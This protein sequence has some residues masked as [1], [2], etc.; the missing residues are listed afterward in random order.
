M[1]HQQFLLMTLAEAPRLVVGRAVLRV[2]AEVPRR[3][4]ARMLRR[5]IPTTLRGTLVILMSHRHHLRRHLHP[6]RHPGHAL[7]R[8]RMVHPRLK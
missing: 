2:D 4:C 7:M 3:S 6:H 8:R 1:R 5:M